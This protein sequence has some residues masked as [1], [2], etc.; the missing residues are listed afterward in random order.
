[1]SKA[2]IVGRVLSIF[3]TERHR[4]PYGLTEADMHRFIQ[5][6]LVARY[7]P[8]Q[9][10]RELARGINPAG[11]PTM[12]VRFVS[13]MLEGIDE[14]VSH[15][16]FRPYLTSSGLLGNLCAILGDP[17]LRAL[18]VNDQWMAQHFVLE[19]LRSVLQ[20]TFERW[21]AHD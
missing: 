12:N 3:T 2:L 19:V 9:V 11:W 6:D 1:M 5:D 7:G 8:E 13:L 21:Y 14:V 15:P 4:S 20:L 17:R 18:D 16:A 10:L